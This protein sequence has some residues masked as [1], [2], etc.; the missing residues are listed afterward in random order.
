MAD[1]SLFT[2]ICLLSCCMSMCVSVRVSVCVPHAAGN[3]C[4]NV[5]GQRRSLPASTVYLYSFCTWSGE[6]EDSENC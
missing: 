6:G 2:V 4:V 1:K 5:C 3:V